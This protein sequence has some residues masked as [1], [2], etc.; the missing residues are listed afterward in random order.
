MTYRHAMIAS[1]FALAVSA[2]HADES[3]IRLKDGPGRDKV[4]NGC[5]MCHSP[6]YVQM[7]SPFLDAKGW[8]AEVTKMIKV[9]GAPVNSDDAKSIIEYLTKYYGKR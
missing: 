3:Q 9:Y 8:D 6:D 2:A 7:N 5:T 4:L 1:A